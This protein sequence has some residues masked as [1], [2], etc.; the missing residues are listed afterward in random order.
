MTCQN[1]HGSTEAIRARI[2]ERT[3]LWSVWAGGWRRWAFP[4]LWLI[5]LIQTAGGV[6]DHSSGVAAVVGY[7]IIGAF[8]VC[9]L[10]AIASGWEQRTRRFWWLYGATFVLT[11]VETI[12]AHADAF[13]FFVYIAVLTVAAMRRWAVPVIVAMALVTLLASRIVPEWGHGLN[14]GGALSVA[15]VGLAMYGFFAVIQS[16]VELAEARAEVARLAAENERS[17]IARDLHDLLGHSLTTIT[18]KA[19]LARRL[20]ERGEHERASGEI[21]E[22]EGLSR[23]TLAD[24][25]AAVAGHRDV[26]LA[27]EL[28]TAREVLRAAGIVAELPGSVDVLHPALS[29]LFGWV[30][31]E[32]ITN[33]VRHS[34]AA[35]C[36][37]GLGANW[38][39]VVDDGRGG[40]SGAGNGLTGLRERVVAAGGSVGVGSAAP[41]WRIR[42][43][44]P[45]TGS[46]LAPAVGHEVT[47]AGPR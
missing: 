7:V 43:D 14:Y 42:V 39:E 31:R 1:S 38:M 16:N 29:E 11:G 19:G 6:H 12:F 21:A 30:L 25:R 15:L 20:A 3:G 37:V 34:H 2:A 10:A 13:V 36:A 35:H 23:R 32:A 8:A 28:A 4:G 47:T 18:V 26:T 40:V 33:V 41:G 44:V 27:G 46:S 24:V 5:Y 22:V 17:R 45:G 9:Y